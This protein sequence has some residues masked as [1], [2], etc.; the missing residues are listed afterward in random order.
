VEQIA[1]VGH[2][3]SRNLKLISRE[4]FKVFQVPTCVKKH[5]PVECTS[6]TV[7]QTDGQVTYCG[8]T[9]LCKASRGKYLEVA[10]L[11]RHCDWLID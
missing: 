1:H 6:G 4:I 10:L 2:S 3:Q 7:R 11:L 8:I 9:P 5:I